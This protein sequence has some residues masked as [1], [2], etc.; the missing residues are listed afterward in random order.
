MI[1]EI[2]RKKLRNLFQG[3]YADDVL[4][5]LEEKKILNRNGKPF[6]KQYIR[7]V[8]QGVRKNKDIEA[9][10]W[11]L[12]SERKK[13]LDEQKLQRQQLFKKS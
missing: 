13:L 2:E 12:A 5:I 9:A 6:N 1:T 7:M 8:F 10:I 4:D 3:Y 11:Q